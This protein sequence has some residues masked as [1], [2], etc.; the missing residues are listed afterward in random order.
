M[1]TGECGSKVAEAG[2]APAKARHEAPRVHHTTRPVRRQRQTP[3][4]NNR[5]CLDTLPQ[6]SRHCSKK[7]GATRDKETHMHEAGSQALGSLL[8]CDRSSVS[9]PKRVSNFVLVFKFR[10]TSF[11][12]RHVGSF[13]R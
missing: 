2:V 13:L 9:L 5:H 10:K 3:L 11:H 12:L 6:R 4:G 1:D 8:S 7:E